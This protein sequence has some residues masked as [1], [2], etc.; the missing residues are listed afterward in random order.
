MNIHAWQFARYFALPL[1]PTRRS[2]GHLRGTETRRLPKMVMRKW[3]F[4]IGTNPVSARPRAAC[5]FV[6][7]VYRDACAP[8][9]PRFK[10]SR[11]RRPCVVIVPGLYDRYRKYQRHDLLGSLLLVNGKPVRSQWV[12]ES[13]G[14]REPGERVRARDPHAPSSIRSSRNRSRPACVRAYKVSRKLRETPSRFP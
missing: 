13:T 2:V 10:T 5:A 7:G 12:N 4:I 1:R 3:E 8:T 9:M 6:G 14:A 11:T